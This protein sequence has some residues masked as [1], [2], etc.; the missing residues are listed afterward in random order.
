VADF[1]GIPARR[2]PLAIALVIVLALTLSAL[3][4][5]FDQTD[6][7]KGISL[8]LTHKPA[9]ASRSVFDAL[10][11]RGE[12]DPRCDGKLVSQLLGD[13]DVVCT[14]PGAPS[15]SY[16]FRVLLDGKRPPHPANPAAEAL[17]AE[18]TAATND[19]GTGR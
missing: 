5:R 13:V 18:M 12:G 11:A 19:G 7:K 10:V 4:G 17:V 16:D 9:G 8:A 1:L 14:T 15:T 2:I 3:Q 6:V